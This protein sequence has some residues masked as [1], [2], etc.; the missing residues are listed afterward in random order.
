MCE[1]GSSI[2][3][4]VKIISDLSC[5]GKEKWKWVEI[6]A[7]IATIVRALQEGGIN[8]LGSCCGHNEQEGYI[9]LADGRHLLIFT[10]EQYQDYISKNCLYK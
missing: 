9:D 3:V 7:C 1:W 8:M 2:P 10:E 5:D 6:D 4:K